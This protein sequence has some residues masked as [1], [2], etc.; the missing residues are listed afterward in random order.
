MQ[1]DPFTVLTHIYV[2]LWYSI[3][4]SNVS[5]NEFPN[6]AIENKQNE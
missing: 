3:E 1:T 4:M 5:Q 6:K 2:L